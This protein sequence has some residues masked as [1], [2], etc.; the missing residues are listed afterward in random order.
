MANA[1]TQG[2]VSL[3]GSFAIIGPVFVC[4]GLARSIKVVGGGD[5]A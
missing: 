1:N 5:S 3:E 2:R 4:V